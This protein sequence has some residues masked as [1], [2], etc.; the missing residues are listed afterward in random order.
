MILLL[1]MFIRFPVRGFF[2]AEGTSVG[3][4]FGAWAAFVAFMFT[5]ETRNK[6]V[7]L[8][9]LLL[10]IAQETIFIYTLIAN[11]LPLIWYLSA[12]KGIVIVICLALLKYNVCF[13]IPK[14]EKKE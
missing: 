3:F 6:I 11:A 5:F 14:E 7:Q 10:E 9:H 13:V 1:L 4:V 8:V 12:L 2:T